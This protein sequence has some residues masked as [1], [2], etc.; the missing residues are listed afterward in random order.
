MS[1]IR[2]GTSSQYATGWDAVFGGAK[3]PRTGGRKA[4]AA[5]SPAKKAAGKK[6]T[7]KNPVKT[8]A[9]KASKPKAAKKAA[10]RR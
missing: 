8:V 3:P 2:V 1:V 10:K 9:K 5:K 6:S 4:V 7:G